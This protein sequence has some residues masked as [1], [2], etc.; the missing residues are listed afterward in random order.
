MVSFTK[1]G[2]NL[3]RS[4]S[5]FPSDR[6]CHQFLSARGF[7]LSFRCR[8]IGGMSDVQSHLLEK[9]PAMAGQFAWFGLAVGG[10]G[11]VGLGSL[12]AW[13]AVAGQGYLA[14]LILFPLLIGAGV[15]VTMV[16]LVRMMQ[17]GHR[18]TVLSAVVAAALLAAILQHYVNYLEWCRPEAVDPATGKDLSE[19]VARLVPGFGDYIQAQA[20]HGR[21][22]AFG[23]VAHGWAVWLTWAV[24]ALLTV[25]AAV[26]VAI[27]AMHT[28]YCNRCRSWYRVTRNGKID[29]ATAKRLAEWVHV[30]LPD[31]TRSQ[32]YRLS[33]CHNGC[34]PTC[35]EL[36][37]EEA[38]GQVSLV[39]FWLDPVGRSQIA[40]ILDGIASET[41]ED[42]DAEE[43]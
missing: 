41:D 19:A 9:P 40:T 21:P 3:L 35:C 34:G 31:H 26:A 6:H 17:V 4:Q 36:S 10:L 23:Y 7:S 43:S 13:W 8:S 16:G 28:P 32:R 11:G 5:P 15:G 24:D 37:W 33:D 12:W 2:Y 1:R 22:L 27:P 25:F 20:R 14:P 18:P 29:V 42:E 39:P 30:A 38:T